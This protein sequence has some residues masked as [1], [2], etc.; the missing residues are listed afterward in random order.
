MSLTSDIATLVVRYEALAAVFDGKK[1]AI[2]AA[3]VAAL[4]AAPA[5][6]RTFWVNQVSGDDNNAGTA[7]APLA[8]ISAAVTRTPFSG[9]CV[10]NLQSDYHCAT[11]IAVDG[12][13][14]Y[15][16]SADATLRNLTFA[17]WVWNFDGT[18]RRALYGFDLAGFS[19]IDI[20]GLTVTIPALGAY[21]GY[22]T[23][24]RAQPFRV[25]SS[26]DG[27]VV[28]L[29]IRY[30]TVY[31]PETPFGQ[32]FDPN[33]VGGI[34]WNSN[35]LTGA[36]YLGKLVVGATATAGTAVSG[37]PNLLSNLTQV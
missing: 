16:R 19:G 36:S 21:S 9:R 34:R 8:S 37:L 25:Q 24:T 27:R 29:A 26:S 31:I 6:T 20:S 7:A 22:T 33:G 1:A 11:N 15:L 2:D 12:R 30:S 5:M 28:T 14:L 23:S 3:V 10:V 18:D 4:A 32:I 13:E 35:T 17:P